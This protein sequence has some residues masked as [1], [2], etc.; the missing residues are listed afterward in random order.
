MR[1]GLIITGLFLLVISSFLQFYDHTAAGPVSVLLFFT[2]II[3]F[4][5]GLVKSKT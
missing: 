1:K 5:I 3:I 4:L 2:G